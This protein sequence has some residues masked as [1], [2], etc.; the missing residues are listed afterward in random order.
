MGP[1]DSEWDES[2]VWWGPFLYNRRRRCPSLHILSVARFLSLLNSF[3]DLQV[4]RFVV[5]PFR[6]NKQRTTDKWGKVSSDWNVGNRK[7]PASGTVNTVEHIDYTYQW[8]VFFFPS[9]SIILIV[10][11]DLRKSNLEN[12]HAKMLHLNCI[13]ITSLYSFIYFS[14]FFLY[15]ARLSD[16]W[17]ALLLA[18]LL[19]ESFLVQINWETN[20][21]LLIIQSFYSGVGDTGSILFRPITRRTY[22]TASLGDNIIITRF[23]L[24]L[25]YQQ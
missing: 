7:E 9:R 2:S 12:F 8:C 16:R 18:T 6:D 4:R 15:G 22:N 17:M 21:K 11:I 10:L 24:V 3:F 14:Y 19:L 23:K 20:R 25:V 1:C 13:N 5:P